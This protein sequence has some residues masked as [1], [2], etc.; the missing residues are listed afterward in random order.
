MSRQRS[1]ADVPHNQIILQYDI[2]PYEFSLEDESTL[3][4]YGIEMFKHYDLLTEFHIK[5]EALRTFFGEVRKLYR[6]E[7][8]FHN[9][10]H[11]WCVMHLSFQILTRGADKYLKPLD[12]FAVLVAAICHDLAHPGNNNLFEVATQSEISKMYIADPPDEICVLERHH[13]KLTKGLL[14][15]ECGQEILK[16]LSR[17]Q[18]EGFYN[19]IFQIIMATDMAKHGE[20][21]KEA[22]AYTSP[23]IISPTAAAAATASS[24]S[25]MSKQ[26]ALDAN[27]HAVSTES[28]SN[29]HNGSSV[30]A[31][32]TVT[33]R[34]SVRI[35][36]IK[37]ALNKNDPESRIRFTRIV[38]H[39]ADIGAQTQCLKIAYKWVDRCYDEFRS[40]A[41][42]ERSLGIVT[43]PFLHE[44][45]LESKKYA[46]QG[47]FISGVIEPMW[48]A[49]SDLLPD[50][51]FAYDQLIA[52]KLAYG[53]K[54]T[55]ENAKEERQRLSSSSSDGT[56]SETAEVSHMVEGCCS[57]DPGDAQPP[58]DVHE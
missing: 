36:A 46:D 10:K 22:I 42:K 19:H 25:S 37:A 8:Q 57:V 41:D 32:A 18:K 23:P 56:T 28:K 53:E 14:T 33:P 40:Q 38:V 35:A 16:G 27:Q 1:E 34:S 45:T 17:P 39:S 29:G 3:I 11:V 6:H 30:K 48:K 52:N 20:L 2:D 4:E 5:E 49:L 43:S 31:V 50:L 24:F 54:V 55:H 12:I 47:G 58:M 13:A 26:N 15:S 51:R 7:N 21:V 44:I 9:F